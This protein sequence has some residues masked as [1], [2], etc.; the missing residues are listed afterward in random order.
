MG[1]DRK[2]GEW[3]EVTVTKD[4]GIR[5]GT[6][7]EKLSSLRP[8]FKPDG[9]TTAGNASQVSD[10]AAAVLMMSRSKAEAA[11]LKTWGVL[12]SFAA[13]GVPP[14]IM[15]VGPLYAIPKAVEQAGLTL[16]DIDLFEINEAFA[17]QALYCCRE[18]GLDMD[19][20]NVNGGAIALGHPL[21]C[22]GTRLTVSIL[23]EMD[24]RGAR[25]GVVSMCVGSG[26]GA[27]AVFERC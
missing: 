12:R 21:G 26:M 18:L 6:T 10:G 5:S 25:Y 7:F 16:D 15:G 2:T 23:H 1:Q 8:A 17:S 11:G 4:E 9:T 14:R 3:K 20:V 24:R 22:T 27:A 13:V 19:K